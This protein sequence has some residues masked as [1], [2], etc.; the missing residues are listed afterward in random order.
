MRWADLDTLDHVNNVVYVEYAAEIR[1]LLETD[2]LVPADAGIGSIAVRFVRPLLL[3]REPVVV[4][5][6]VDGDVLTQQICLDGDDGRTLHA[7]VVTTYGESAPARRR[8]DVPT[9]AS[10]VRRT[11]LDGTG[12]VRHPRV[13]EL[14]QEARILTISSR[15]SRLSPGSFVIGSS[16]V[17]FRSPIAWRPQAYAAGAWVDRIGRASFDIRAELSDGDT[18]LA[19]STTTLV[20]F[21]LAAQSSRPF[22]DDERAQLEGLIP[23]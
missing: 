7:E 1:A 14:F 10:T 4:L 22:G 3:T 9:L 23:A 11:D 15:L 13:F 19:S 2:G 8:I 20:G 21:D 18:V 6:T 5:S 12:I 16:T 17:D